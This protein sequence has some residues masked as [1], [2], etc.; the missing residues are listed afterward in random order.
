MRC[1]DIVFHAAELRGQGLVVEQG[2]GRAGVAVARLADA[3]RVE[4]QAVTDKVDDVLVV[5]QEVV[6]LH[7]LLVKNEGHLH[8]RVAY[9]AETGLE[10]GEVL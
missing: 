2:K 10:V 1:G 9:Q 5:Q 8:V 6:E 7:R 3:A 4:D